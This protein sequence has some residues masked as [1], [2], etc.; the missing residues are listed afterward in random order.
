MPGQCPPITI[1][2]YLTPAYGNIPTYMLLMLAV[3][4]VIIDVKR[5][6]T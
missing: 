5:I 4:S 2:W 3:I 6:S 1:P